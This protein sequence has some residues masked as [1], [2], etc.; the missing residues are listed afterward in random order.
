M[1]HTTAEKRRDRD[2]QILL[3]DCRRSGDHVDFDMGPASGGDAR[4]DKRDPQYQMT[5]QI[6]APRMPDWKNCASKSAKAPSPPSG[7]RKS[8]RS[9][10]SILVTTRLKRLLFRHTSAH[11]GHS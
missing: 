5:D 4:A 9:K 6:I 11:R 8:A 7:R 1:V 2:I 10:S 3:S